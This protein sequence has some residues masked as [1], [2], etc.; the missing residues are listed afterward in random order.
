ML[1][2]AQY[3][4]WDDFL[5]VEG[6]GPRD[7]KLLAL[8]RFLDSLHGCAES[9]WH[10]WALALA[11]E[12]VDGRNEMVIRMPLFERAVFPALIAGFRTGSPGCA[13]WLAGLS[14]QLYRNPNDESSYNWPSRR[15]WGC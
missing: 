14:Q 13:R 3:A 15:R 4:L 8:N 10:P 7:Q 12:A 11:K 6:R 1:T 2:D 9:D 5:R